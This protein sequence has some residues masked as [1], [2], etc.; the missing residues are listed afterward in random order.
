MIRGGSEIGPAAL[1]HFYTIHTTIIPFCLVIFMA[2]HFWRVRKAGGVVIPLYCEENSEQRPEYVATIPNLVVREG[3]VALV[4]IAFILVL[5]VLFN[6]PLGAKANPGMSPNP[7]KAPW[8]FIGIQELLL[9]FHP[10]FA[11]FI[12]PILLTGALFFFPYFRYHSKRTGVWFFSGKGRR[13]GVVSA[14]TAMIITPVVIIGDEF[15]LDLTA[16]MPWVPPAISNG[17][18]PVIILLAAIIGFYTRIKRIYD[19]SNNEAVQALFIL[20][21]VS[22][23]ILTAT[24]LWFRGAGMALTWP[25]KMNI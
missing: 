12:I 3:V 24:A 4:L 2:F 14:F 13:M 7:A 22:F 21:V 25:W 23:I 8:Y 19:A 5:S 16:L 17:L 6:A 20:L 9:H 1:L 15:F 11:V 10:L 18:L